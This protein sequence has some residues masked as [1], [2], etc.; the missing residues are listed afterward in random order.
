MS[1]ADA[2]ERSAIELNAAVDVVRGEFVEVY[3]SPRPARDR[4]EL[5]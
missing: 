1:N 3:F 2:D 4:E 5:V